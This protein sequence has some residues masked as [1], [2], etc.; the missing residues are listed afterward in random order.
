MVRPTRSVVVTNR[1]IVRAPGECN[2]MKTR[3]VYVQNVGMSGFASCE[4]AGIWLTLKPRP[5]LRVRPAGPADISKGCRGF[6]RKAAPR[7]E[8]PR[9]RA[10]SRPI[11]AIWPRGW[12]GSRASMSQKKIAPRA[13]R[14]VDCSVPH[15]SDW[16]FNCLVRGGR[17]WPGTHVATT[18]ASVSTF[19][20]IN[21]EA[22]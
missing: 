16:H 3:P 18:K 2:L 11:R 15:C 17:W 12:H 8:L 7:R 21:R 1:D 4:A 9:N 14:P 10:S 5:G 22:Q 20:I 6:N 13:G 19:R